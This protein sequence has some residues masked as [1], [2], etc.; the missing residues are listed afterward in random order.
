[1]AGVVLERVS[2]VYPGGVKAVNDVS[3]EVA[4]QEL[5]VLVGPSGCGKSTTLRLIAGL[6]ELTSGTIRIG[7]RVVN[8]MAPKDRDIAMVFQ[9]YALYPHMS[10]YKNMA[11]GLQL[12]YGGNWIKRAW[13]RITQPEKA[14][15]MA[16]HR[17]EIPQRVRQTAQ[18][19]GIEPLLGRLPGQL[20]GGERQRVALGRAIVRQPAAFLFDE[21][22]SNLDAKLRVDMR[23][24]V[25]QL[26]NRLAATMIYVTHDQVEAMTLGDRIVVLDRGR[27]QQ[28]GTPLEIYDSP[29]NRFV[30]GFIGTPSMNFCQGRVTVGESR[31]AA[32]AGGA[33]ERAEKKAI[34]ER[35]L[36][37]AAAGWSA[38][39]DTET[40]RRLGGFVNREL[41]LGIRPEDVKLGEDVA[42]SPVQQRIEARV[43]LVEPLGDAQIVHLTLD[44]T[45]EGAAVSRAVGAEGKEESLLVCKLDSRRPVTAGQRVAAWLDT[46]RAHW[47]DPASGESVKK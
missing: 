22:L 13:W 7:G 9:N 23:R 8:D 25:K 29:Q 14:R 28:V 47:F 12:R 39:L 45:D 38:P 5:V 15:A 44:S 30:A 2:R 6:E 26:H 11:F 19:L 36:W 40:S 24:E 17:R 3:L 46:R 1:M 21:P 35:G 27:V 41:V 32:E 33:A 10:V 18:G 20:S 42:A 43:A 34:G 37:F 31:S 4:D 16:M